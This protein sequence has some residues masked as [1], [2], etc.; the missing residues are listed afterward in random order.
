MSLAVWSYSLLILQQLQRHRQKKQFVFKSLLG[1]LNYASTLQ[2][3]IDVISAIIQ[4]VTWKG[5]KFLYA[6]CVGV[7][8][9]TSLKSMAKLPFISLGLIDQPGAG[10][11][12]VTRTPLKWLNLLWFTSDDTHHLILW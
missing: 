11:E 7:Y 3:E 5:K 8:I 9:L 1:A 12:T 2:R 4:D 10:L 6:V